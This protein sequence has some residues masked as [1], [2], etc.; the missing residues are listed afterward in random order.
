MA[1]VCVVAAASVKR[2]RSLSLSEWLVLGT[3]IATVAL[4]QSRAALAAVAAATA[5]MIVRRSAP[6]IVALLFAVA[7]AAVLIV[8]LTGVG[9]VGVVDAIDVRGDSDGSNGR[10]D[11]VW[12]AALDAIA[13]QPVSGWGLAGTDIAMRQAM[14]AGEVPTMLARSAHNQWLETSLALGIVGLV[15]L[16]VIAVEVAGV[17]RS[18]GI[19]ALLVYLLVVGITGP[20]SGA[21][22]S[23]AGEVTLLL[24]MVIL[25][26]QARPIRTA[27]PSQTAAYLDPQLFG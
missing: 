18:P 24:V 4:S 13:E 17:V 2:F 25:L 19:E 15:L 7:G 16:A 20:G 22:F 6:A 3:G 14:E 12:P 23:S 8:A 26:R 1:A 27:P 5:W 10:V 9:P 11:S 21:M